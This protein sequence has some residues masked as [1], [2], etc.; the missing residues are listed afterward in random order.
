MGDFD[1]V[2]FMANY[3]MSRSIS[4]FAIMPPQAIDKANK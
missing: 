3:G 4:T 1:D 2:A